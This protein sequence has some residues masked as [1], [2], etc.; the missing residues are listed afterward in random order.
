[1]AKVIKFEV[2]DKVMIAASSKYYAQNSINNPRDVV[3]TVSAIRA[4]SSLP[5]RVE[6]Q[7]NGGNSYN[8]SDLVF[9]NT[10]DSYTVN[11]EFVLEAYEEACTEWKEKIKKEV[12]NL[13]DKKVN[14]KASFIT[15]AYKAADT[16][17]K[18]KIKAKFPQLFKD[19]PE[20][21]RIVSDSHTDL[22]RLSSKLFAY[23][24]ETDSYTELEGVELI[25]G[26]AGTANVPVD[27]R[28]CGLYINSELNTKVDII[29]SNI[30]LK[31]SSVIYFKKK[32]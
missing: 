3:G 17:W 8:H 21:V 24:Y 23:S 13:Y 9:A 27:T 11:R 28:C 29:H 20:Y 16:Q 19:E 2:G 1:M 25:Q 26:I 22:E 30:E 7:N 5:L 32:Q 18:A 6:W 10:E 4:A 12:P 15:E 14:I 31:Q